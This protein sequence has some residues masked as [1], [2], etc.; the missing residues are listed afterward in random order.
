MLVKQMLIES[1]TYV[2]ALMTTLKTF[3]NEL[4]ER[5]SQELHIV[6]STH[7]NNDIIERYLLRR[8]LK[9]VL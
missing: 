7:I 8:L 2:I 1:E 6:I 3:N 4:Y 5:T 9:F